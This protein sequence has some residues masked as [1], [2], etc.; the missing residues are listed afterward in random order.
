[1]EGKTKLTALLLLLLAIPIALAVEVTPQIWNVDYNYTGS[2]P[3][4]TFT[5]SNPEN[6]SKTITLVPSG[7]IT[8]WILISTPTITIQPQSSYDVNI[9]LNIPQT[10]SGTYVGYI[11]FEDKQIPVI[12]NILQQQTQKCRI[13]VT[14]DYYSTS[15]TKDSNPT[16]KTFAVSVSKYCQDGIDIKKPI[17]IGGIQT[18][19]GLK[20]VDISVT[21]LGFIEPSQEGSFDLRFDV[22][23]LQ[24]GTYTQTIQVYGYYLGDKITT[25]LQVQVT[26]VGS[27]TPLENGTIQQPQFQI[28]DT[29]KKGEPFEIRAINVNP[30]LEINVLPNPDLIGLGVTE[31][32]NDWIYKA[33][34][35]KTGVFTIKIQTTYQGGQIG[36]LYEKDIE[37]IGEGYLGGSRQLKLIFNPPIEEASEGDNV[38]ILVADAVTGKIIEDA[39]IYLNGIELTNN[40]ITVHSGDSL[41]VDHPDYET[42]YYDINITK[43]EL[44]IDLSPASPNLGDKVTVKVYSQSMQEVNATI[45]FDGSLVENNTFVVDTI[46]NHTVTAEAKGYL[47]TN[48]TFFVEEVINVVSSP[49]EIKKGKEVEFVL[50]KETDWEVRY[51]EDYSSEEK[52]ITTGSGDKVTFKPKDYGIYTITSNGKEVYSF[53]LEKKGSR[54]WFWFLVFIAVAVIITI[55]ILIIKAKSGSIEGPKYALEMPMSKLE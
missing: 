43:E 4:Q 11:N 9:A 41:I 7:Q 52:I 17:V 34:I 51:R 38:S 2:L 12:V 10:S 1:M 19:T 33:Y 8:D 47:T 27:A 31:Q 18:D 25:N 55:I 24:E 26:V 48:K 16:T 20:P 3:Q 49:E 13:E 22:S 37:V 54:F 14:P 28:P 5:F 50:N 42:L 46:G 45:Y 40:T 53:S 15:I 29:V 36:P 39:K 32:G 21:N 44:I 30:N 6:V 23:G 35:N